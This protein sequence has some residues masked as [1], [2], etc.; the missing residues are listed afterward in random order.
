[1]GSKSSSRLVE[2]LLSA[3]DGAAPEQCRALLDSAAE[4]GRG[5]SDP[6]HSRLLRLLTHLEYSEEEAL[7]ILGAAV[8]HRQT[9]HSLLGRDVGTRVALFDHLVGVDR[10]ILNPKIIEIPAF[11]RIERSAVTDHLTGLY[12]RLYF[13]ARLKTE[14]GRARRFG[15]HLSLLFLDLDDFKAVNDSAGHPAGDLV[16]REVGRLIVE[17]IR[18]IDIGAR[19]GGEEF[20]IILPETPRSGAYVVAE[21]LRRQVAGSFRRRGAAKIPRTTISGGLATFPEDA[22]DADTL[23]ERADSALYRAK[24]AGKNAIN[25]YFFEKRRAERIDVGE[26]GVRA[27]V[28]LRASRGEVRRNARVKNISQDGLLIELSE[29]VPVG[30]EIKVSFS[31]GLAQAYTIPST[32][33]RLARH[34]VNGK[35]RR[36]EAGL[37]FQRRARSLKPELTRLARQHAAAG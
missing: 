16:L 2:K 1:M 18:D 5:S 29:P 32:V 22:E 23:I 19:Y 30:S 10:R 11:E 3:L 31:L 20:A 36:F 21:R 34:A 37:R 12:N 6:V 33:V 35:R 4:E 9:L 13:D 28:Q 24:R 14:V 17:Q 27:I 7:A 8:L 15:Q 25:I 26:S